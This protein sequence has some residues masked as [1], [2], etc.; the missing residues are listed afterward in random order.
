MLTV[1]TFVTFIEYSCHDAFLEDVEK[2]VGIICDIGRTGN[3]GS[4]LK[5]AKEMDGLAIPSLL[6]FIYGL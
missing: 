5:S 6:K 2:V 3:M 1:G 4:D